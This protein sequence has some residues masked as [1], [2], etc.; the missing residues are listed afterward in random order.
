M[1]P[2][3]T[4][5]PLPPP[6]RLERPAALPQLMGLQDVQLPLQ[7]AV[8]KAYEELMNTALEDGYRWVLRALSCRRHPVPPT[9]FS[10]TPAVMH[11]HVPAPSS[12]RPGSELARL[13]KEKILFAA[14]ER[15]LGVRGRTALLSPSVQASAG[16]FGSRCRHSRQPDARLP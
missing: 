15:L 14:R 16:W 9:A 11:P 6:A 12:A 5:P 13:G 3:A 4:L 7:P 10:A 2:A 1:S 8:E